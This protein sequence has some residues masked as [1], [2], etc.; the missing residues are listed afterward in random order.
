MD[1]RTDF[2]SH[3]FLAADSLGVQQ[4]ISAA[5]EAYIKE[6]LKLNSL[7]WSLQYQLNIKSEDYFSGWCF[8]LYAR[9][10][11]F[12]QS[13]YMLA[14]SGLR[15]QANTQVRCA[16]EVLFKL[17]ALKNDRNLYHA[18]YISELK[19]QLSHANSFL[20]YLERNKGSKELRAQAQARKKSLEVDL[21][22]QFHTHYPKRIQEYGEKDAIK[23]FSLPVSELASKAGLL[24]LYDLIYR[25]TSAAT[26]SDAK[27][28]EFGH[29][30]LTHDGKIESLKNEPYIDE[31]DDFLLS[32]AQLIFEA[33]E[34]ICVALHIEKPEV[35]MHKIK[36]RLS[37]LC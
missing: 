30:E 4:H 33:L 32:L 24:D 10:L 19:D 27:S 31:F 13:A 23:K 7:A 20:S 34:F 8:A 29:F 6:Y 3:G 2:E 17:G 5:F 18:Y 37:E 9:F 36:T 1:F 21:S 28:L 12:T 26:H 15:D 11:N 16:L 25:L 22:K 14:L 35:A